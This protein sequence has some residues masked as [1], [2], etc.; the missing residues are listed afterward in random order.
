MA[1]LEGG[2]KRKE[3]IF[4]SISG[5]RKKKVYSLI[6]FFILLATIYFRYIERYNQTPK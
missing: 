3:T 1:F 2:K 6:H 4:D 5:W